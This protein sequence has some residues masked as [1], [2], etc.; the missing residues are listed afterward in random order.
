MMTPTLTLAL[1]KGRLLKESLPRLAQSGLIIDD[2]ILREGRK[3]L[4]GSNR[5]DVQAARVRSFDVAS[6]VAFGGADMGIV[7]SD[8]LMEFDYPELYMPCD[9]QIGQCRLVVAQSQDNAEDDDPEQWSH[10]RIATKYPRTSHQYF[11]LRGIQAECIKL[12][13]AVELAIELGIA[14]Y[15]VDLVSSG[16]T[17]KEHNLVE[18]ETIAHVSA[19][20]IINRIALKT[21][22]PLI[23]DIVRAINTPSPQKT[24]QKKAGAS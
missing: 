13:G 8:V 21:K 20:L 18:V 9:L 10:I 12:N 6:F 17:L 19:R 1:P 2:A 4:F 7:G 3:L 15:I 11:A 22:A 14:P 16:A 23:E 5:A 24:V